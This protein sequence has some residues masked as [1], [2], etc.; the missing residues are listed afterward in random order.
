MNLIIAFIIV[1]NFGVC[2]ALIWQI[3]RAKDEAARYEALNILK[4]NVSKLDLGLYEQR[5]FSFDSSSCFVQYESIRFSIRLHKYKYRK[6][7]AEITI[8]YFNQVEFEVLESRFCGLSFSDLRA[9][10]QHMVERL[11]AKLIRATMH[12]GVLTQNDIISIMLDE[13]TRVRSRETLITIIDQSIVK[14]I[15]ES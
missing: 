13:T 6:Y 5:T 8:D 3:R 14:R 10:I 9:T 11:N 15:M 12:L 2:F 7:D 1:F 4:T